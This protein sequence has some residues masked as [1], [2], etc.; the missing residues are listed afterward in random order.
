MKKLF[1]AIAV[2]PLL[3]LATAAMAA[4]P[5]QLTNAQMDKVTAGSASGALILLSA[6]ASGTSNALSQTQAAATITQ[7]NVVFVTPFGNVSLSAGTVLATGAS[8]SAN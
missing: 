8:T 5:V 6:M 1:A 3:G 2:V 4:E 7:S